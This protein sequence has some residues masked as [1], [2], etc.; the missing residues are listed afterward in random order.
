MLEE[1]SKMEFPLLL[2]YIYISAIFLISSFDFIAI[3]ILLECIAFSSYV[4]VGY[5]R[6]NK[7]S[8]AA[9]LKYLIMATIP[10][11]LFILACAILYANFGTFYQNYI[12]SVLA[13]ITTK[14]LI[15]PN[16]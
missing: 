14:K 16:E 11:A 8:A 6:K 7:F 4:L 10:S 1:N 15:D 2:F 9:A 13:S 3:I 5:E 12:N